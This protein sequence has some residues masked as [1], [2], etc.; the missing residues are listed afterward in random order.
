MTSPL[1]TDK[2]CQKLPRIGS[3]WTQIIQIWDFLRSVFTQTN[4]TEIWSE[5]VPGF[6]HL[7]SIWHTLRLNDIPSD[8]WLCFVTV[9]IA[10]D[11]QDMY[12]DCPAKQYLHISYANRGR[13]ADLYQQ[14]P[15]QGTIATVDCRSLVSQKLILQ[16]WVGYFYL[17]ENGLHGL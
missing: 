1:T 17:K 3:Y 16:K 10:C 4:F 5:K 13:T 11:H 2:I 7:G 12:I 15:L 8:H 14:C 6:S 9:A